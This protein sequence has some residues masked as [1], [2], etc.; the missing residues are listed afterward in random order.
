MFRKITI[1]LASSWLCVVGGY[2]YELN[3]ADE[4]WSGS[5]SASQYQ[6]LTDVDGSGIDV[7]I[8]ILLSGASSLASST[9]ISGENMILGIDYKNRN[10]YHNYIDV[11]IS[12]S[13][14]VDNVSFS[15]ND[16][17]K[18]G[19][20]SNA[21]WED[22]IENISGNGL[23]NN[24]TN[25]SATWGSGITADSNSD[26]GETMYRGTESNNWDNA[27][28]LN[29]AWSN[30]VDSLTFRYSGGENTI[31]NPNYQVIG[32]SGIRF[33]EYN[34]VPEP[35]T[36]LFGGM[37]LAAIVFTFLRKRKRNMKSMNVMSEETK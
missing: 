37:S 18:G 17:D 28:Q 1:L 35:S 23:N 36:Y 3:W 34:A 8:S 11:T 19:T 32:F 2:A 24:P 9:Q 14:Y 10:R 22:V 29:L 7:S 33:H 31:S 27:S 30:P 25:A 21:Y 4:N 13:S 6:T 26:W 16:V 12:F 20:G 15:L 5:Y